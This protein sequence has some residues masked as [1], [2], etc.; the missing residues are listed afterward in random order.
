[1][2]RL[3]WLLL[4]IIMMFSVTFS[5]EMLSVYIVLKASYD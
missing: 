2:T 4:G 3:T 1:M 5:V